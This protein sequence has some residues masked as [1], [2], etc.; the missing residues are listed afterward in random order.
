MRSP[1]PLALAL[2]VLV[3]AVPGAAGAQSAADLADQLTRLRGEVEELSEQLTTQKADARNELQA[4]ARQQAE[5]QGELDRERVRLEKLRAAVARKREQVDQTT[6]QG[7]ALAP[8]FDAGLAAMRAHVE[9]SLPFRR[10]ERLAELDKL[11]A[12]RDS[13]VLSAPRALARLWGFVE[14]ELRMTRENAM[15]Q[16]TIELDG[17]ERLADVVR[18]GMVMLFFRTLEGDVGHA[19]LTADGWRFVRVDGAAGRKQVRGLFDSFKKQ[20]RTG[21]FHLP[22]A[23]PTTGPLPT[24]GQ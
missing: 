6:Q 3:A 24:T 21:L 5:L 20:I 12:Q 14:D 23:L 17:T 7:A 2:L 10:R 18:V 4:L 8:V 9:R 22:N 19:L 16:Q 15:F 11:A 13:G 1:W